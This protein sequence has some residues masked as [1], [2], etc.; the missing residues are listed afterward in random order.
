MTHVCVRDWRKLNSSF[1]VDMRLTL[2]K[3]LFASLATSA[4]TLSGCGT[5]QSG[6]PASFVPATHGLATLSGPANAGGG[7]GGATGG[8]GGGGGG[9]TSGGGGGGNVTLNAIVV[10]DAAFPNVLG[11]LVYSQV[12]GFQKL[13]GDIVDIGV[14][15][16]PPSAIQFDVGLFVK[17][18][19]VN[20]AVI[21]PTNGFPLS[22][23]TLCPDITA[24]SVDCSA[25]AG[26][27]A[28]APGGG[29]PAQTVPVLTAGAQVDVQIFKGVL[30][31]SIYAANGRTNVQHIATAI[32]R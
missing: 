5:T 32:L 27:F 30:G 19:L 10:A 17:G 7:G 9:T 8:G 6:T 1:E 23:Q 12:G 28:H 18:V 11:S 24:T 21:A 22:L 16:P 25:F 20:Y 3:F 26:E 4:I 13:T 29:V 14:V 15:Q 31:L 2:V